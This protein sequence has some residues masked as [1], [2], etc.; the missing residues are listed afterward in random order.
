M[1]SRNTILSAI[2]VVMFII[3]RLHILRTLHLRGLHIWL[4]PVRTKLRFVPSHQSVL[5]VSFNFISFH[6]SCRGD[7]EDCL[8]EHKIE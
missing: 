8:W 4:P 7:L 3:Q 1:A 2:T 5:V 6:F